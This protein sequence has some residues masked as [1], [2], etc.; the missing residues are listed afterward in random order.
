M[1]AA[2]DLAPPKAP[3]PPPA[4]SSKGRT[5][6]GIPASL[7]KAAAGSAERYFGDHL[8]NATG[9]TAPAG[10]SEDAREV[11]MRFGVEAALAFAPADAVEG[12]IVA[13][14]IAMHHAA[15][16]FT[17]R[18]M[19]AEF[20][21][22]AQAN[23]KAAANASRTFSEL[24]GA[25]DRKRGK[26]PQVVR[27]ER[28]VIHEGGQAIVG[29]VNGAGQG[30]GGAGK[31]EGE[32]HAPALG[33][34]AGAGAIGSAL[35]GPDPSGHALLLAG[36]AERAVPHARRRKHRPAHCGGSG[37]AAGGKHSPRALRRGS[38]GPAGGDPAAPAGGAAGHRPGRVDRGARE[39]N[40]AA[41]V[42]VAAVDGI[43]AE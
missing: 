40:Q 3:E 7:A 39:P 24:L 15:M 17:R 42:L 2:R 1:T 18:A 13:Q 36:D 26:G 38:G 4:P 28:V 30:G 34:V 5:V 43:D 19:T 9:Q 29:N 21:D 12:L 33:T 6:V 32:A 16:D 25:L 22:V 37:S 35:R 14:A 10:A 41:P 31:I 27:V 8:L 23:L 20:S 11:A